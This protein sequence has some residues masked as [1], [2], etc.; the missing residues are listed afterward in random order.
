MKNG[1]E[2]ENRRENRGESENRNVNRG[3]REFRGKSGGEVQCPSTSLPATNSEY[4]CTLYK[5]TFN[6]DLH[7]NGLQ[8]GVKGPA[9]LN[10]LHSNA[11]RPKMQAFWNVEKWQNWT[12]SLEISKYW[13]GLT[14]HEI[15][16]IFMNFWKCLRVK[17]FELQVQAWTDV[18]SKTAHLCWIWAQIHW[19]LSTF[20]HKSA[21]LFKFQ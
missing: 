10:V 13:N 4:I 2:R 5:C 20:L 8:F 9:V 18:L 3:E 15:S 17:G 19:N 16:W 14:F 21:Y 6:L 1:R 7:W 12:F 11:T